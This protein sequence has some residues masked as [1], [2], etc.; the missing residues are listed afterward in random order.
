MKR[1]PHRAPGA[2]RLAGHSHRRGGA[3]LMEVLM[4]ILIMGIGLV[5]VAS[6]FPISVLRSV[7]ANY[8]T[9]GTTHRYNGEQILKAFPH[10]LFDPDNGGTYQDVNNNPKNNTQNGFDINGFNLSVFMIDPQA[11]TN[12]VNLSRTVGLMYRYDGFTTYSQGQPSQTLTPSFAD[13][14]STSPDSW[15]TRYEVVATNATANTAVLPGLTAQNIFVPVD[16]TTGN[17][18]TDTTPR[19]RAVIF[20]ST[21]TASQTRPLDQQVNTTPLSANTVDNTPNSIGWA[22][23]LPNNFGSV[24][25]V[26]IQTQAR[27]FTWLM[28]V[29]KQ[30]ASYDVTVAVFHNRDLSPNL[31]VAYG[32]AGG[33]PADTIGQATGNPQ[34]FYA[35]Q[36]T[37][38][39][40]WNAAT[41]QAPYLRKGAW[42]LDT[43]SGYWYR[44][45]SF[46]T[47]AGMATI[48]LDTPAK[49][50]SGLN[51]TGV[52]VFY[53]GIVD[54][55]PIGNLS[56]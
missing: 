34:V 2:V 20:N 56:P 7:Q 19:V 31:D 45:E 5:S 25:K 17:Q 1:L 26:L 36:P 53:K 16:P 6:L 38:F 46:T 41:T 52:A 37:M 35:G 24:G 11:V 54:V 15:K 13:W 55:Y 39:V 4:A 18:P 50:G 44:I 12:N 51:G 23:P 14:V 8:L 3:T 21:S 40:T 29:R 43:G 49:A 10:L 22:T 33:N 47:T 42:V 9:F 27:D 32:N 28:T 48:T 30:F